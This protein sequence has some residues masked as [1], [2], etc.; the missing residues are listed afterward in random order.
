ME[1]L[2]SVLLAWESMKANKLRSL[3]TMLG[4]IIGVSSVITVVAIGQGGR[5]AID[6]EMESFGA[7]RFGIYYTSDSNTPIT[8]AD[9]FTLQD[10]NALMEV[11][12]AVKDA[13]PVSWDS[14]EIRN[15]G[16]YMGVQLVA[17]TESY[18]SIANLKV[19]EGR[20]LSKDDDS[21]RSPVTVISAP[22]ARELFGSGDAAGESIT[23][24][25]RPFR[26]IGVL[27]EEQ[28]LFSGGQENMVLYVPISTYFSLYEIRWISNIHGKATSGE[29]VDNAIDQSL[30]ILHRRHH[31]KNKYEAWNS[32]KEMDSVRQV[33]GIVALIISAIAAISL[34]VGGI[35]V[36]N[37]MLVSVTERTREIGI[38]KAL[39]AR[40]SDI[41]LQFL[42]ES[43]VLTFTGGTMGMILGMGLSFLLA[44][45]IKM[46]PVI[47]WQMAVTAFVFSAG[48]GIFFGLYPARRAAYQDPI[49][50]LRYE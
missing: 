37:I 4:I 8:G 45:L 17:T 13:A 25:N 50:A 6:S 9:E 47:S 39:G 21:A 36:M 38:R 34:V 40:E 28:S 31:N 3:L 27:K 20:F 18:A 33:T 22:L 1:I 42:I 26:V 46:P 16:K 24:N 35:G 29:E 23:V 2:E 10:I 12:P 30:N 32:E 44:K 48:V 41:M 49:E 19:S 5:A 7:N 43:M 14:A 15:K 11:A